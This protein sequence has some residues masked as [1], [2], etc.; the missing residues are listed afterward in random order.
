MKTE[1]RLVLQNQSFRVA[2]IIEQFPAGIKSRKKLFLQPE[3]VM[4]DGGNAVFRVIAYPAWRVKGAWVIGKKITSTETSNGSVIPFKEPLAFGNNEIPLSAYRMKR[5]KVGKKIK[6]KYGAWERFFRRICG[7]PRLLE[8]A[9][10]R[11]HTRISENPHME[12]D[13]TMESE[14]TAMQWESNPSPPAKPMY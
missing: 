4:L 12:Y 6:K 8:S 5:K 2:D 11:C 1:A 3:L 9:V 14:G 10:F 7:N 13:V